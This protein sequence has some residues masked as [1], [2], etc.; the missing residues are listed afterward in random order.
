MAKVH[1]YLMF[2]GN[3]KAAF[4]FYKKAF[5]I[6]FSDFS[7]FSDMPPQE[8]MP[9]FSDEEKKRVLH[10]KLEITPGNFL[11]GSDILKS[12]D[13]FHRGD[14]FQVSIETTSRNE[15][16]EI[17]N[18]LSEDG[19]ITMPLSGTFWGAYFGMWKDRFGVNWMVNYDDPAHVI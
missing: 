6:E 4:D 3:C 11:Y 2:D 13:T 14:G 10:V 8:G 17:F 1:P 19:E 18:K 9:E 7:L 12:D 16:T 5:G 15:A